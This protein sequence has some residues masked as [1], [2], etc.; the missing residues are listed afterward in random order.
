MKKLQALAVAFICFSGLTAQQSLKYVNESDGLKME[1]DYS[2]DDQEIRDILSFEGID[3]MKLKFENE[4][5]A[6]WK[7][8]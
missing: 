4:I 8:D 7:Q 5:F 1:T 3:Y 2:S 6:S